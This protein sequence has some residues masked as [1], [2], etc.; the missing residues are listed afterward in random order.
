MVQQGR[1]VNDFGAFP[2]HQFLNKGFSA[3]TWPFLAE[4]EIT[5]HEV[6][7]EGSIV[8]GFFVIARLGT[9]FDANAVTGCQIEKPGEAQIGGVLVPNYDV[10]WGQSGGE[11]TLNDRSNHSRSGAAVRPWHRVDFDPDDVL[12]RDQAAPGFGDG[13]FAGK[14]GDSPVYHAADNPRARAVGVCG[15]RVADTDNTG[16][17]ANVRRGEK[18][19]C[20]GVR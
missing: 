14:I 8:E 15:R 1:N 3:N 19:S 17:R 18:F 2:A 5:P 10:F 16:D 9:A 12:R 4:F 13:S 7:Q 20:S 6:S 11:Q